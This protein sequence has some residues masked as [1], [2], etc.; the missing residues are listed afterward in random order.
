MSVFD[1]DVVGAEEQR[2][3]FRFRLNGRDYSLPHIASLTYREQRQIDNG[4]VVGVIRKHAGD[5]VA[6]AL[7]DSPGTKVAALHVQWLKHAGHKPG[8]SEA[9]SR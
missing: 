9:S 7:L 5:E 6:E 4:D 3:P 2:E 1:L 8:E